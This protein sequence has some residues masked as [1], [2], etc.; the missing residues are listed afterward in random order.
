MELL[1]ERYKKQIS[2]QLGCYDRM[3]I[4]GTLP[5][6]CYAQGMTSYLYSKKIRIFDY[7]KFAEPYKNKIREN[8]EALAKENG[9]EI[10]F[11]KNSKARK[12]DIVQKAIEKNGR[13]KGLLHILSAME[14]CPSYTPWHDKPTGKTFL[15][16]ATSKCLHYYFYFKDDALG[17]GYIRVPTWCPFRLQIY[18]NGH[19]LVA[20]ELQKQGIGYT[21][22]DNAFE[23][24]DNFEKAQQIADTLNIKT[25]HKALDQLATIFCPISLTSFSKNVVLCVIH[26]SLNIFTN[27]SKL[28]WR[29][30]KNNGQIF[31]S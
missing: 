31:L 9:I 13:Q 6:L 2:G 26:N 16:G 4:T 27:P 29:V 8:A 10:E 1:T 5:T 14:M 21:L 11:V 3:I 12:E 23:H 7:P 15:K 20:K 17:Y 28:H 25:I 30:V 24:I 22:T 19:S 18:F